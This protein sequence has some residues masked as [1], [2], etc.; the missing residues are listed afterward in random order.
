[1]SEIFVSKAVDENGDGLD[2][3]TVVM[4]GAGGTSE[5]YRWFSELWSWEVGVRLRV[6]DGLE[7]CEGG[8]WGYVWGLPETFRLD[9]LES[10]VVG[11]ACAAPG[12]YL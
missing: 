3:W 1:M 6:T 2:V 4:V 12:R 5:G 10:E 9:N 8:R 11:G 7:S